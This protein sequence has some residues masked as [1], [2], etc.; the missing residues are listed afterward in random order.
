LLFEV[1][2]LNVFKVDAALPFGKLAHKP[3]KWISA[4]NLRDLLVRLGA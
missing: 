3:I 2:A 1:S 4:E